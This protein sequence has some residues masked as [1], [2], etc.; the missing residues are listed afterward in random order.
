[1]EMR[2][3][4]SRGPGLICPPLPYSIPFV[5]CKH[6]SFPEWL[7][8]HGPLVPDVKRFVIIPIYLLLLTVLTLALVQKQKLLRIPGASSEVGA[9]CHLLSLLH[10]EEKRILF[11]KKNHM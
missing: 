5:L 4:G 11:H 2:K 10:C 3:V 1:M 9:G 8:N 7:S 6:L